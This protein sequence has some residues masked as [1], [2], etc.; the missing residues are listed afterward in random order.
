[1]EGGPIDRS[2]LPCCVAVLAVGHFS[3]V[4]DSNNIEFA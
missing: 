3:K 4:H 1:M 2:R